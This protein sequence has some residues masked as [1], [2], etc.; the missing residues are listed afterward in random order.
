MR[1]RRN[2]L[3]FAG[4]VAIG[5][6]TL[7]ACSSSPSSS[8]AQAGSKSSSASSSSA[9]ALGNK[10]ASGTPI[11]LGFINENAGSIITFPEATAAAQAAV[12]YINNNLGGVD[13]HP[14]HLDSCV[15][16][17]TPSS[18]ESCAQQMVADHVVGVFGGV[19]LN[20]DAWY[21]TL[22]SANIPVV[23]GVPLT[24][25][26]YVA[27]DA[28]NYFGGDVTAT[29]STGLYVHEFMPKVKSVS[30]LTTSTNAAASTIAEIKNPLQHWGVSVKVVDASATQN[31]WTAPYISA[32]SSQAIILLP[33][34]QNCISTAQAQASQH[35][36]VPVVTVSTCFNSSVLKAT[37]GEMNGWVESS[38]T[39][40][41]PQGTS[42]D[43]KI[44]QAVMAKYAP[45][46][47]LN[48]FA[49]VTFENIMTTYQSVLEPLGFAN[50]TPT[51]IEK[52]ITR[53]AGG[54]VFLGTTYKCPGAAPYPAICNTQARFYKIEGNNVTSP[55]PVVNVQPAFN[56]FNS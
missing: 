21:S 17:G 7:A 46:S 18:S 53:P 11:Q 19:D 33:T 13:G 50:V 10:T 55:T 29:A 1:N 15:T 8:S 22:N 9:S 5:A 31:D 14:I 40:S 45:T 34:D 2:R 23:G 51:N 41:N 27:K 52:Q 36:H 44:F 12:D 16:D 26:D 30:I 48:G 47:I 43:A 39:M 25:A 20:M 4:I 35:S 54:K 42:A 38:Q 3:R 24:P 28:Y 32:E 56:L 37:N 6:L 49:P